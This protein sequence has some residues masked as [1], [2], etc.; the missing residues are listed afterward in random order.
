MEKTKKKH[1]SYFLKIHTTSVKILK[2]E[3]VFSAC[4]STERM[5]RR[6]ENRETAALGEYIHPPV[7]QFHDL[8]THPNYGDTTEQD[9][10]YTIIKYITFPSK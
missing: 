5:P 4:R 7:L 1:A 6:R 9:L 10:I 8:K 3:W 2:M